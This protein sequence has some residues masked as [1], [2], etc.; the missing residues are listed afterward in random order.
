L[1]DLGCTMGQGYY[2]SKPLPV[3]DAIVYGSARSR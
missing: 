3:A 2:F 1:C